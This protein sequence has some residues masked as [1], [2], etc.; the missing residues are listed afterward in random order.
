[1]TYNLPPHKEFRLSIKLL[2]KLIKQTQTAHLFLLK[3]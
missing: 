1:M 3:Q 2:R